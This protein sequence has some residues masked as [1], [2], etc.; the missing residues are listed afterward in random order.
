[1]TREKTT[2][3]IK[4]LGLPLTRNFRTQSPSLVR[5]VDGEPLIYDQRKRGQDEQVQFNVA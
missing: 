5:R 1:M 4:D 2:T 3:R